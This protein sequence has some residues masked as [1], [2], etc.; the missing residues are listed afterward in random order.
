MLHQKY[1]PCNRVR[2]MPFKIGAF[3]NMKFFY[4]IYRTLKKLLTH[5]VP[6]VAFL[7]MCICQYDF[8]LIPMEHFLFSFVLFDV[9]F[10]QI[11]FV[12]SHD[13]K[14]DNGSMQQR[15]L[16]GVPVL[17]WPT[18]NVASDDWLADM[19][20]KIANTKVQAEHCY[21]CGDSAFGINCV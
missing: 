4:F 17:A 20:G 7:K 13:P 2:V 9:P 10:S 6:I 12:A 8:L 1:S 14:K 15:R 16:S 3:V 5:W 21:Y 18:K 11:L 19:Y